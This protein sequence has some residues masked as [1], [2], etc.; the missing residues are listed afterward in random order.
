MNSQSPTE[1]PEPTVSRR[2]IIGTAA[3]T[4]PAIA[5]SV[6][7][8]AAAASGRTPTV[9]FIELPPGI[10]AGGTFGDV[11]ISATTDGTTPAP[12]G[13]IITVYLSAVT[14]SDGS[15]MKEFV[16]S[17][18]LESVRVSG[19]TS[20]ADSITSANPIT[21]LY[22]SVTTS[23]FLDVTAVA[24]KLGSVYAWGYNGQGQA[25]DGT[26]A[27]RTSPAA[28]KGGEKFTSIY[29]GWSHFA[30]VTAA[31]TVYMT[32]NNGSGPFANGKASGN[33][34]QGPV[35]PA[36]DATASNSFTIASHVADTQGMYDQTTWI[37]GTDGRIYAGGENS[38]DMFS[39]ND[40]T[41]N[42]AADNP[43][44]G[45]RPVGQEILRANPGK[46]VVWAS[47]NGWYRAAYLLS[48]G[49]V[50]NSGSNNHY[51]MGNNGTIGKQYLAAQTVTSTGAPLTGIVQVRV[52]K[53]STM[54]LDGDG[55]LWG[56][57][58]NTY[59]QLP[60]AGALKAEAKT[61]VRLTQ[62]DGKKV[63]RIWANSA[64]TESFFART[65]DG[66]VYSVG[67]N[68]TGSSG[69][70]HSNS[71]ANTWTRVVMPAGKSLA[72]VGGGGNGNLFLMTDGTVYFAGLNDTGGAGN[73]TTG[74]QITTMSRVTLP[75]R[76]IDIA[77]TFYDS[78]AAILAD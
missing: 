60:G 77:S 70:G 5:L 47:G 62:P 30:A 59:G 52:T 39:L 71:I 50:W 65:T 31:H 64:D 7:S 66:V 26:T 67:A 76:V 21:A 2:T 15:R 13:S 53:K 44:G 78:Y 45:L 38:S 18:T 72:K 16:A 29:G 75:A 25:G 57:G 22:E 49:T 36:L 48:D 69:V 55:N 14:F 8:P 4:A 1:K 9:S 73:G 3:W 20:A 54:Y 51:G 46:S 68:Q 27:L 6:A 41:P 40:G 10:I 12:A 24:P 19:I 35:G 11:V 43:K 23:A 42:G 34:A 74:G 58:T 17:G 56:A 28:W 37:F 61:A 32:G 63:E 33:S